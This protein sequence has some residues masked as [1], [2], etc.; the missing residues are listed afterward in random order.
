[1]PLQ[2]TDGQVCHTHLL[3][4]H[5]SLSWLQKLS[6]PIH[7]L[8]YFICFKILQAVAG[9]KHQSSGPLIPKN[10]WLSAW[11][12]SSRQY[13]SAD[14]T[15]LI[16]RMTLHLYAVSFHYYLDVHYNNDS[17]WS[18][19]SRETSAT[20]PFTSAVVTT[21]V[22]SPRCS[23]AI[24]SKELNIELSWVSLLFSDSKA[25]RRAK[26]HFKV[27]QCCQVLCLVIAKYWLS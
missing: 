23:A 25:A 18:K 5:K 3:L 8:I 2:Q 11:N 4:Q 15:C 6:Q 10:N 20:W 14:A 1:M 24:F 22:T 12:S 27:T 13:Y 7:D 16:A 26:Q 21:A 9:A 17:Q 19:W